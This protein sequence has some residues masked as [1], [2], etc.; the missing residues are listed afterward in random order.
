MPLSRIRLWA[1]LSFLVLAVQR[2]SGA[3]QEIADYTDCGSTDFVTQQ[4]LVDF[5]DDT[6]W[7]NISVVGQFNQTVID[8]NDQTNLA[9]TC[10]TFG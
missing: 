2:A 8:S 10:V 7:L 6:Y 4:I 3:W 1:I 5:N 9:S